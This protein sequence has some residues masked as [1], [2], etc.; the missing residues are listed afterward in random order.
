ML[1]LTSFCRYFYSTYFL[2]ISCLHEYTTTFSIGLPSDIC[3]SSQIISKL[4]ASKCYPAVYTA[5]DTGFYGLIKLHENEEGI[6]IGPVYSTPIKRETVR[7]FMLLHRISPDKL[8]E[9]EQQLTVM[10]CYSYNQFLNLLA[11]LH[12][13]LNQEEVSVTDHFAVS[14]IAFK[15]EIISQYVR[16]A[17]LAHDEQRQRETYFFEQR[18]LDYVKRGNED[19]LR[20]FLLDSIQK[21]EL[22]EG[23][24][25]DDILRQA[26]DVFIRAVT[27]VGKDG[28]IP[29]GMDIEQVY[30]LIDAYIQECEY[31]TSV[32]SIKNLQFNMLI[33]FTRRVAQAQMPNDI[34]PEINKCI[35]YISSHI[36]ETIGVDDVA[37]AIDK[38][39]A[40][41]TS[42]F[43]KETGFS[44][45]EYITRFRMRE[46]KA[47]LK[48]SD[49]NIVQI[50]TYLN[51]AN[52]G[53]FQ[54]VFKKYYGVT[55]NKFRQNRK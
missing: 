19:E 12:F 33:D 31:L 49:M 7:N 54:T 21:L 42:K 27:I 55:P 16:Q 34:S 23:K 38:S 22:P 48:Y 28:A 14:E 10:P 36:C 45:T 11:F 9:L 5:A 26:K 39:R 52:Q 18:M 8:E 53:Y 4:Y 43:R 37:A 13:I 15:D 32:D 29:G 6:L 50:S 41:T 17:T 44:I 3:A 24:L 40:Y 47:L 35:R 20:K 30:Y 25:S 1:N 2:P 46:A 51:Y